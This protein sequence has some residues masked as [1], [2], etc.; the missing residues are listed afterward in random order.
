MNYR[1][2]TKE[3]DEIWNMLFRERGRCQS[4]EKAICFANNFLGK[5]GV[6]EARVLREDTNL[7]V[8]HIK[9]V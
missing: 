3:E 9:N 7:E 8:W 2:E 6:L 5:H 4:L 1:V